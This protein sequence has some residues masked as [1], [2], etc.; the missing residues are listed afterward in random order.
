VLER[1]SEFLPPAVINLPQNRHKAISIFVGTLGLDDDESL[2]WSLKY[3]DKSKKKTDFWDL[4]HSRS[5]RRN[6]P[7]DLMF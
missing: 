7:T 3:L 1:G 2:N 5:D 6:S 4:L